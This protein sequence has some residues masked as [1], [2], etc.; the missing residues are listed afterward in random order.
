MLEG[1][2][3]KSVLI[4]GSTEQVAKACDLIAGQLLMTQVT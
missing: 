3:E 4:E 1:S 2:T